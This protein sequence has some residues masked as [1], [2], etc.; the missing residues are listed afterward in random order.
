MTGSSFMTDFNDDFLFEALKHH[1]GFPSFQVGQIEVIRSI[2]QNRPTLAVMPTGAGKSLCYQLPALL[3]PGLTLVVSPL[4]S[5]MKDQ[6]DS[7]NEK[8][9]PAAYLNSTLSTEDQSQVLRTLTRGG[10]KLLYV[11][12]ERFKQARF[13]SA[14]RKIE[15]ALIAIDEAHCISRWGHEFRPDYSRL[16]EYLTQLQVPRIL[17]C[18]ATAT[19]Y[20]RQDILKTLNLDQPY[21]HVAGFLR[22]NLFIEIKNC[23]GGDKK[24]QEYL[25]AFLAKQTQGSIIIYATTRKKVEQYTQFCQDLLGEKHVCAYHGG[26]SDRLRS[27]AQDRFMSGKVRVVVATNAFG[28]GVD[29]SDV[30]GVVHIDLPR[31]LEGY[32]QE[33]G[34]AGRDQKPA[35]CLLLFGLIDSKI[36]RFLIERSHVSMKGMQRVWNLIKAAPFT[37]THDALIPIL[38][39]AQLGDPEPILRQLDRHDT[40]VFDPREQTYAVAD[41][42]LH[43][44]DVEDLP[45]SIEDLD[46]HRQHELDKH[47]DLVRFALAHSCRHTHLLKYFGEHAQGKCPTPAECDRCQGERTTLSSDLPLGEEACEAEIRLI[48]KAL[49]GVARAK[50]R[51]GMRKVADMLYGS[52][53]KKI[54]DT[55]LVKLSTY[56]LLNYLSV[57]Q[58]KE[59]LMHLIDGGLCEL[60][61]DEYPRIS[62]TPVGWQVM[63]TQNRPQVRLSPDV[64]LAERRAH[65]MSKHL[66][67]YLPSPSSSASRTSISKKNSSNSQQ[68]WAKKSR[69][70]QEKIDAKRTDHQE[71]DSSP[72]DQS[73]FEE[74]SSES[75]LNDPTSFRLWGSNSSSTLNSVSDAPPV[76]P[77]LHPSS[78]STL[79]PSPTLSSA[80]T[81]SSSSWKS[82]QMTP[83]Q[84]QDQS[85]KHALKNYRLEQSRLLDVPAFVI[86]SNQVLDRLVEL[87]PYDQTSFLAIRGLG[88]SKWSRHGSG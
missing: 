8:E 76:S 4:I 42:Y 24:R 75:Q 58:C 81:L 68:L 67:P 78:S 53:S 22:K 11:A 69:P 74:S 60:S 43:I 31:T 64:V 3:L 66:S 54:K 72:A 85:L 44:D 56:G 83:Q 88:P 2:L 80:S 82:H 20:V 71:A 49:S 35:Q 1:F 61:A 40:L 70:F 5:L 32:Y 84:A 46:R 62:I 79:S 33:I 36:H 63:T 77:H 30:R 55:S 41:H 87:K 29:R 59:I 28:M 37:Y 34:R 12:P 26:M 6:V 65:R 38:K 27:Q 86:F 47:Q 25:Q 23:G 10:Y 45:V 17:A 7:L 16:G 51:F 73:E 21:V 19:P 48:R 50:G 57:T 15:L 14:L 52:Q 9:I 18:T 13:L 39:K